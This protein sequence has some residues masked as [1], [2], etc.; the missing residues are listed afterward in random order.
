MN[1]AI[2]LALAGAGGWLLWEYF[3]PQLKTAS[4]PPA[5]GDPTKTAPAGATTTAPPPATAA[6]WL[7]FSTALKNAGVTTAQQLNCDQW[8]YYY[9]QV[10]PAPA[11]GLDGPCLG[12][13]GAHLN[14]AYNVWRAWMSSKGLG[15]LGA[16]QRAPRSGY[17]R[18]PAFGWRTQ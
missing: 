10:A 16:F 3:K 4:P 5:T 8:N 9:N 15:R 17:L 7:D 12:P 2:K 6:I 14:V 18:T 1:T 11:P 13:D